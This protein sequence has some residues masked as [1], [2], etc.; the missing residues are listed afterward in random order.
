MSGW[1]LLQKYVSAFLTYFNVDIFRVIHCAEI[2]Q[3]V[4]A[5][6]TEGIDPFIAIYLVYP[7]RGEIQEPPLLPSQWCL[8]AP[9]FNLKEINGNC[10][11]L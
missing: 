9:V 5:F 3:V 2:T 4:S 6:L 11:L 10:Y 7:L 8:K 1:A